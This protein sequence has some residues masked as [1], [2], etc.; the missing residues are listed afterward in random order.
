[1][2][3]NSS[4]WVWQIFYGTKATATAA[5]AII[6]ND[7]RAGVWIPKQGDPPMPVDIAGSQAMF[8]VQTRIGNPISTPSGLLAVNPALVRRL[9]GA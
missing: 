6:D 2:M 7:A 3:G 5:K 9:V 4:E 1:M 8:A